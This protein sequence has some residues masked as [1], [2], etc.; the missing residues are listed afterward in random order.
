MTRT[1]FING[2]YCAAEEAQ[3]SIFNRGLLFADAIY[4]V[5]TV[6]D[7]KLLEFALRMQRLDRSLREMGFASPFGHDALLEML[8]QLVRRNAIEE[9]LVY[10]QITRG[11]DGDREFLPPAEP[12]PTIF[13]FTQAKSEATKREPRGHLDLQRARHSLGP[14]R[15][16]DCGPDGQCLCQA[17]RGQAGR[18]EGTA[19]PGR[20]CDRRRCHQL[21]HDRRRD[22]RHPPALERYPAWLHPPCTAGPPGRERREARRAAFHA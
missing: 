5:M 8:C 14:P 15:Y 20:L 17:K 7:G 4:E 16:Q 3:V 2:R 18:R 13:A 12:K 6:M 1:V 11:S 9:G 10:F 22:H 21:L 19:A